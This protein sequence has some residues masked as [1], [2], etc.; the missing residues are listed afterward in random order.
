MRNFQKIVRWLSSLK[1]AILLLI[2]IAIA[3]AIGTAI[4]QGE[5]PQNYINKYDSNPLIGLIN[6]QILL[7]MQLDHIYSSFWFL[8]L[9]LWLGLAL[10]IC[11][12]RRQWPTLQAAFKWID[13]K[14]PR[15]IKK[16]LLAQ[17]IQVKDTSAALNTLS[18]N[19]QSKGW[20]IKFQ[21]GRLAARK[22]SIGR[23]GPPLVHLGLIFLM[24]GSVLGVLNGQKI[25]RFLAPGRSLDL[26]NKNGVNQLTLKLNEF[27]IERDS[28]GRPEQFKSSIELD[29]ITENKLVREISVNHPLRFR[30]IT[31]YQADWALAAIKLQLNNSPILQLPL[32][33]ISELGNQIWGVVIPTNI[34]SQEPVLITLSNEKGPIQI[35]NETGLKIATLFPGQESKKV[36]GISMKITEV[37][38]SS[39]IL[40]KRDPGVPLVY[41]GFGITLI[42]SFLSVLCTRQLWVVEEVE[43]N[44]LHVGGICNRNLSRFSNE[45]PNLLNGLSN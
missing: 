4:P 45:L 25:E 14:S 3:S 26:V 34:D 38:P 30:G 37:I 20:A 2:I 23:V 41:S 16:L 9:L 17:T 42:G 24:I 5:P 12:W 22:G 29:P 1:V 6:G 10:I 36:N 39:G 28:I 21:T 32:E 7:L 18:T 35:F 40:I 19:L 8:S 13:Y 11:S 27:D 44:S 15:Q 31:V 33:S 43:Q